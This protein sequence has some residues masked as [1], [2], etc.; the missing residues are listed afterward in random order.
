MNPTGWIDSFLASEG[1][2]ESYRRTI[3]RVHVPLAERV[4]AQ[5]AAAGG[6]M[7]TMGLCGPQGSGKSTTVG[8][9]RKL[10]ECLG[11]SVA[12]LS[13]DDLYLT[14]AERATLG[15][16]VH[17][18]FQTRGVPGTHD[19]ALGIELIEALRSPGQ[20]ALPSFDK[21]RDDRRPRE[22]WPSKQGPVHV[23]LFEGWCLGAR[24]QADEALSA[25]VNA[26]ERDEDPDGTWRRY[27]NTALAGEYQRLFGTVELLV[28]L[29]VPSFDVVFQWRME[30]ER[31]LRDRMAA[32]GTDVSRVMSEAQ[33]SR[34]IN[35]YQRL[36]T[37]IIEEMPARADVLLN[38]D[39]QREI[40]I[41]RI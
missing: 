28:L 31:K 20:V 30:Q 9:V 1:L 25:P 11:L 37:H 10:L 26:L 15:R 41:E 4:A 38:L 27:V 39:A 23:L 3:E 35:H 24:P 29:K 7:L 6:K 5:A 14:H 13:L 22:E 2:P 18:L 40:A 21:A 19:V 32:S 17:P 33:M 12:A 8:S 16:K 34:F 36:T